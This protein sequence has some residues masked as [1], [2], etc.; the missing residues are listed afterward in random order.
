MPNSLRRASIPSRRLPREPVRRRREGSLDQACGDGEC[1]SST[2]LEPLSST[3]EKG[4]SL[5]LVLAAPDAVRFPDAQR[6]L[7]A[8][9]PDR[10]ASAD[11]LGAGL[12]GVLLLLSLEVV[13][14]EEQRGLLSP[15]GPLELPPH[16][17]LV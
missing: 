5:E 7:E 16:G 8:F 11:G 1:T 2:R 12:P 10:A 9:G 17:P 13:G 6:V 4:P 15:A 3:A 14:S